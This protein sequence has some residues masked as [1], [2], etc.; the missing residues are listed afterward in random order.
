MKPADRKPVGKSRA[1]TFGRHF[2]VMFHG[3][4]VGVK[5]QPYAKLAEIEWSPWS[6]SRART[7]TRERK[8]SAGKK[9]GRF[10]ICAS[11]FGSA[12]I[13]RSPF[14]SSA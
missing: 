9:A 1:L 12:R 11:T 7:H 2:Q 14:T 13:W 10:A 3:V 6:A 4:M 5:V 8:F